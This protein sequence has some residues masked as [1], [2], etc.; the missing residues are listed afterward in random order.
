MCTSTH[1]S[2]GR[3]RCV[4]YSLIF[5]FQPEYMRAYAFNILLWQLILAIHQNLFL[6]FHR[7][8]LT[9]HFLASL[10]FHAA[11]WHSSRQRNENRTNDQP[12]KAH[13]IE[14]SHR[15]TVIHPPSSWLSGVYHGELRSH[16]LKTEE[17]L[18]V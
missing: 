4:A 10:L 17:A 5:E 15:C 16:M 18:L 9:L 6:L 8:T 7:Y 12:L 2:W 14:T 11:I 3:V 1:I 13:H